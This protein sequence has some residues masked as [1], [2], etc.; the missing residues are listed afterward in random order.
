MTSREDAPAPAVLLPV[1]VKVIVYA[2]NLYTE[3]GFPLYRYVPLADMVRHGQPIPW[4]SGWGDYIASWIST[5]V[6]LPRTTSEVPVVEKGLDFQSRT[7]AVRDYEQAVYRG[8]PL[9]TCGYDAP[10][11]AREAQG[12]VPGLFELV[13]VEEPWVLDDQ[14]QLPGYPKYDMGP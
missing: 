6:P 7:G 5:Y 11:F 1:A 13:S 8:W 9:Y 4:A 14:E 10:G 2:G 3:T 12:T